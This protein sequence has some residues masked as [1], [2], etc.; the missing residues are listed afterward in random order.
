MDESLI[1]DDDIKN[2]LGLKNI[3]EFEV[4]LINILIKQNI[5]N[6]ERITHRCLTE[7]HTE[8][9]LIDS[10]RYRKHGMYNVYN[11]PHR[12]IRELS[13]EKGDILKLRYLMS[14][15]D[16]LSGDVVQQGFGKTFFISE[17]QLFLRFA[18]FKFIVLIKY[19]FGDGYTNDTLPEDIK[20]LI[21]KMVVRDFLLS[22]EN[23]LE[24]Q[25]DTE[26]GNI[27]KDAKYKILSE[28][29]DK[30]LINYSELIFI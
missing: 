9:M 15:K 5:Q 16:Y 14:E 20:L 2:F 7:K 23:S 4:T 1:N 26:K 12:N 10:G 17:G 18:F 21:V 28:D 6:F 3:D 29:I 24:I 30:E 13:V 19:R 8:E 25:S 22:Y 27:L 11:L